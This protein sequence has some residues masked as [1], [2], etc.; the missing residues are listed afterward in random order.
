MLFLRTISTS[1][2]DA[3]SQTIAQT[4]MVNKLSR[5]FLKL[6]YQFIFNWYII[7]K[8]IIRRHILVV[9]NFLCSVYYCWK[10]N[11]YIVTSYEDLAWSSREATMYRMMSLLIVSRD[12]YRICTLARSQIWQSTTY[13][14][15]CHLILNTKRKRKRYDSV[16]WQTPPTLTEK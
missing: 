12:S 1:F 8:R 15:W 7:L 4:R 3:C 6:Y 11:T 16:L 13:S 14:C 10:I 5:I 2:L 9:L